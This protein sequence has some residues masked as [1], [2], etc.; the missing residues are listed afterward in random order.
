MHAGACAAVGKA[1]VRVHRRPRVAL[2][3]TGAELRPAG[4]KVGAHQVRNSNGPALAAAL[5]TWGFAEVAELS[6]P[7]NLRTLI[8]RL[9][10]ALRAGQV[11]LVTGGVSVGKYDYV[12]R[13]VEAVGGRVRFHGVAMKPGRPLLY[14][15]AGGGRHVFGLPGNPLSAMVAFHEF[16][17]PALRR[18]AGFAPGRCRPGLWLPLAGALAAK[19]GPMRFLPARLSWTPRGPV[20][21]PVWSLGSADLVSAGRADGVIAVPAGTRALAAGELVEFRPWR[22][23]P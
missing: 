20:V 9:R 3:A 16:A 2:V 1:S 11:V 15:T 10:R 14:A 13:A 8:A 18:L 6:S 22:P 7:D 17:L 12:R 19:G 4:A 5:R 23:L 21:E